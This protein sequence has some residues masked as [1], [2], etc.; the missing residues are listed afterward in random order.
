MTSHC[1]FEDVRSS[2][3]TCSLECGE[4]SIAVALPVG[5]SEKSP[6]WQPARATAA[7]ATVVRFMNTPT[8][9]LARMALH[10]L[11]GR[12]LHEVEPGL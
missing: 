10:E 4:Y 6:V 3:F 1:E 9:S 7:R 8:P 5:A 11:F 2:V 12:P